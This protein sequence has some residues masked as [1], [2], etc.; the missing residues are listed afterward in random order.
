M[1]AW[2]LKIPSPAVMTKGRK[3]ST[4]LAG[5]LVFQLLLGL[6]A[7]ECRIFMCFVEHSTDDK[8]RPECWRKSLF[9]ARSGVY[10]LLDY[11]FLAHE[12]P[13]VVTYFTVS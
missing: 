2:K 13:P 4:L 6:L 11:G 3:A 12:A 9:L 7:V 5:F 1:E 10:S 8:V